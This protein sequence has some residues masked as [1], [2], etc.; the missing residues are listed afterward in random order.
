MPKQ[1][2]SEDQLERLT[3]YMF[4]LR[5][6]EL[7]TGLWPN[8]RLRITRFGATGFIDDGAS[9]FGAFCTGCH[10]P[11]GRGGLPNANSSRKDFPPLNQLAARYQLYDSDDVETV[12]EELREHGALSAG[13]RSRSCDG[14]SP[15]PSTAWC[16]P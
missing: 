4:S 9:L 14:T 10:G 5:R 13:D 8:D 12:V 2:L 3:F 11:G 7:P 6:R 16:G 15:W 1:D